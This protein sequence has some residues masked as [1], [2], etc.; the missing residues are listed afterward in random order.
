M[1]TNGVLVKGYPKSVEAY[2]PRRGNN[3][4]FILHLLRASLMIG[5]KP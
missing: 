3:T 1:L 2:R 5:F 4:P